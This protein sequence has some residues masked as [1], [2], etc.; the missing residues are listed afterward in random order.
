MPGKIKPIEFDRRGRFFEMQPRWQS[1]AYGTRNPVP[2]LTGT[3]GWAL[4][5]ASALGTG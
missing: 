4:F 3:K 1:D 2:M 5:V